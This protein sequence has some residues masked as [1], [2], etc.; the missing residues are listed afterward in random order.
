MSN[1]KEK[2]EKMKSAKSVVAAVTVAAVGAGI[3]VA[4]ALALNNKKNRTQVKKV[5]TNV[6]DQA[7]DYIDGM[8]NKTQDKA[9]EVDK[10]LS[11]V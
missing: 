6:K 2:N 11:R 1:Q 4:A 3:A 8:Q 7:G 5:L 10:K 9:A